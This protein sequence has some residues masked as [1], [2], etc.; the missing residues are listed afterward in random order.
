[1][2][3]GLVRRGFSPTGGA[4]SY[5]K[6]LGRA[7]KDAGHQ[8]ALYT[9]RAWPQPEWPYGP[10]I[11]SDVSSPLQFAKAVQGC[12]RPDEI[13]F[14]LERILQC[15]CYRAGDGVHKLWLAIRVAHEPAWR[16]FFRFANHK[17]RELLQL[18]RNLF[19]QKGARHVIAN[20][21][22]VRK[23]IINEFA[24]PPEKISVVY[25]GL[26]NNHFKRKPQSRLAM[27]RRWGL[28]ENDIAFLFAGS[29]WD[30][31]G[32]K[33]G[34]QAI[35]RIS[36]PNVRLLVA[37]TGQKRSYRSEKVRFLGPVPDMD[38]LFAAADMFILPTV[39]DPF[40]N[41][42]LEA[43]SYGLPVITTLTN[44]FSEIVESGRHG[45]IIGRA[46]DVEALQQAMEKWIDP[47]RRESARD[48]CAELARGYTMER[49]LSETLQV[50][51]NL[52]TSDGESVGGS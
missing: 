2:K 34:L 47:I 20:S 42:C 8:P 49:N 24:Y 1:M 41:A 28:R 29:G 35:E 3:I 48:Q 40:S 7:L 5:L 4:E 6:R 45:E 12:R 27:R 26:P 17:H 30:R 9:T 14:S 25:N 46:E 32:L 33:Y 52:G 10:V 22:M 36:N 39:Y 15:D 43:L 44:G 13:L 38:S 19:E 51:E 16:A 11:R 21:D 23:E 31:K 18:E 37:G 50:L